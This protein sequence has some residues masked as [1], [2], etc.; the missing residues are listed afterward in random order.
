MVPPAHPE[1]DA[2]V[3]PT[4]LRLLPRE[5]P[6]TLV[7]IPCLNEGPRIGGIIAEVKQLHPTFDILIVDD[8][9]EDDTCR[10]AVRAGA[11]VVRLP[12]HLG[13]G[14]ALQ[15]GYRYA[16]EHN[17]ERLVQ[18]DGDGQHP[19]GEIGGLLDRLNQGD[20]DLVVGSRFLGRAD[21]RIPW[22]RKMG[23]GLF[24]R[25]TGWLIGRPVTDPTSGL[26]AMNTDVLR[27]YEQ[28]FY[29]YDYPDA[30]MLLRVHY[31]GLRFVEAP[32]VMRGGPPGKSMHT[33]MRPVYY[34]YKLLLSL[35]LTWLSGS[36]HKNE[37]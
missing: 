12:L 20:A 25:L 35:A 11:D 23:I 15:T 10:A 36:A 21:Y 4:A 24:G 14:A 28:D 30:D 1:R 17:Y 22:A 26:Q 16:L 13:Y 33:G 3:S 31:A 6:R 32:V 29:P 27:F 5:A 8:G 34:V 18:M 2:D 37:R 7:L 19:P 9:S